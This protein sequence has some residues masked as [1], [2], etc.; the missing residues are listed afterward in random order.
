MILVLKE[1]EYNK[2]NQIGFTEKRSHKKILSEGPYEDDRKASSENY[3]R[4]GRK[5]KSEEKEKPK[6]PDLPAEIIYETGT[7]LEG[8]ELIRF[9]MINKEVYE[10]M[11]KKEKNVEK[12]GD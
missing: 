11:R 9:S 12:K 5:G 3:P 2:N 1:L 7:K 10:M 8:P 4:N 6:P